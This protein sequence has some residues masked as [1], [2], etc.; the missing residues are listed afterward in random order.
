MR[1]TPTRKQQDKHSTHKVST[2][3]VDRQLN[4]FEGLEPPRGTLRPPSPKWVQK[5]CTNLELMLAAP[6]K[7]R[8]RGRMF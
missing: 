3:K 8:R 2:P 6:R 1:E 4:L 5:A 7:S